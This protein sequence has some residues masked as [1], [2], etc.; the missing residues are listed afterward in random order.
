MITQ[1]DLG[2]VNAYLVEEN[3]AYMLV[4]TGGY[5]FADGKNLNN[6][7]AILEEKLQEKGVTKENL[8]LLFLTHGDCDHCMNADYIAKKYEVPIAMHE[9]D[10]C[11]VDKPELEQLMKTVNYRS[12]AMKFVSKMIHGMITK[13]VMQTIKDFECF[14]PDIL[15]K[16]GVRLDQYG[17]SVSVIGLAGH[18]PG[19]VGIVTDDGEAIVG[20][21]GPGTINAFD[22][23]KYDR[24]LNKIMQAGYRTIYMGHKSQARSN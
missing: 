17:F 6:R 14:R 3:G 23:E 5:L 11:L 20:D 9:A 16:D 2:A 18:T 13:L 1:L 24:S 8:K 7:R 10:V 4:D 12:F 21:A 22:F 15:V 19:S